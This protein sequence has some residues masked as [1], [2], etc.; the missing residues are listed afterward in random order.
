MDDHIATGSVTV[1]EMLESSENGDDPYA[2]ALDDVGAKWFFLT[3][4]TASKTLPR[5]KV[6][7]TRLTLEKFAGELEEK[8][9]GLW[10]DYEDQIERMSGVG[11][12]S[13]RPSWTA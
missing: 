3:D 5:I 12:S 7:A 11:D 9:M 8:R 13:N 4:T 2:D 1:G 6:R 10:M